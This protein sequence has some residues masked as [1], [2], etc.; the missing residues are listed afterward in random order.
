MVAGAASDGTRANYASAPVMWARYGVGPPA[1][2]SLHDLFLS[3]LNPG[4]R[5]LTFCRFLSWMVDEQEVRPS[6]A[7]RLFTG[8]RFYFVTHFQCILVFTDPSLVMAKRT[9]ALAIPVARW[10]NR[11]NG[12]AP[13]PFVE[14]L[15]EQMREVYWSTS[16][17]T[18]F[19]KMQ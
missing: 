17:A 9:M 15:I 19:M 16:T 8:L 2:Y 18:L 13:L 1:G 14:E 6:V 11:P 3:A 10:A 5:A 12:Q 7:V 4:E